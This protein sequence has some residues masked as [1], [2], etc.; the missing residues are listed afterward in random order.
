[1]R[2]SACHIVAAA[3]ARVSYNRSIRHNR[4]GR[5]HDW[6]LISFNQ[7]F[8]QADAL[9]NTPPSHTSAYALRLPKGDDSY[10]TVYDFDYPSRA[11]Q[12][13]LK[14]YFSCLHEAAPYQY[15]TR[16]L[17]QAVAG[18][19][20][21]LN[22]NPDLGFM[23]RLDL[24]DMYGSVDLCNMLQQK[25]G[26]HFI[27][28]WLGIMSA[29]RVSVSGGALIGDSPLTTAGHDP[30]GLPQGSALSSI[31]AEIFVKDLV[32]DCEEMNGAPHFFN[33]VDDFLA[34]FSSEVDAQSWLNA[35]R[36]HIEQSSAGRLLTSQTEI[37][38]ADS[39]VYFL[40]HHIRKNEGR[41]IALP[42]GSNIQRITAKFF[43]Q[44]ANDTNG[45]HCSAN[46]L[47]G[48]LRSC[49]GTLTCYRNWEDRTHFLSHLRRIV[50]CG[51][52][53]Y[54]SMPPSGDQSYSNAQITAFFQSLAETL[55]NF[56][57]ETMNRSEI[58]REL[59]SVLYGTNASPRTTI[60]TEYLDTLFRIIGT[61][62]FP[63][64]YV[65]RSEQYDPFAYD[66]PGA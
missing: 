3:D 23:V 62:H 37:L 11:W 4:D 32:N 20:E 2:S 17:D 65:P 29:E 44:I 53:D 56:N 48:R 36:A 9:R 12:N 27:E 58:S 61:L 57:P 41:S 38:D 16:G 47:E 45:W 63:T 19:M 21:S 5:K 34:I 52:E 7:V 39:G 14:T 64:L 25:H 42:R 1:M 35:V 31:L 26:N 51:F 24:R 33:F 13:L 40:G 18:I 28:R 49:A 54:Q 55:E 10:R 50:D 30:Q 15:L 59:A 60:L 8:R 6:P 66:P 22:R 43:T 46:I